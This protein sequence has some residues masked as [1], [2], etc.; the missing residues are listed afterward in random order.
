M[1]K[2]KTVIITGA[3]GTIGAAAA[4]LLSQQGYHLI[5]VDNKEEELI[6]LTSHIP[7][8]NW[9]SIDVTNPQAIATLF[10][11]IA[12]SL[13]SLVLAAGV[14]GPVSI[15]EDCPDDIFQ[16]VMTTNVMSIWLG[17]KHALRIFKPKNQ[18][19]IVVLSSISGTTAMPMLSPYC[20]SKH[21]VIGLVRTAA[22]EVASYGIRVNAVCPGPVVSDMMKRIDNSL[23][24]F[25]PTR[26]NNRTDASHFIP[27]QRY[28]TPEEVA[29]VI[30]FLCSDESRYCTGMTMMVDGGLSC[31]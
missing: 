25:Y 28:A 14:E 23:T 12:D 3:A 21:A 29:N 20:A 18:G 15:L 5:L 27:M 10:D 24:E 6:A 13:V 22:R 8:S 19:S 30:G 26:L 16:S 11:S 9:I 4:R 1:T 7:N 2:Q 17:I 31:K